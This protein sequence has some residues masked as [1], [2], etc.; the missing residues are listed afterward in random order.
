MFTLESPNRGDSN[1][2]TQYT[3]FFQYENKKTHPKLSQIY[4]YGIFFKGLKNE[5]ERSVVNEPSVFES[6]KFYC[7]FKR[8][9]KGMDIVD[10]R[11]TSFPRVRKAMLTEQHMLRL[12]NKLLLLLLQ[13][14]FTSTVNI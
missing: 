2:Y 10:N 7:N 11:I 6:L 1:E 14:C 8:I 4:S 5:F 9:Q 12:T 13:C 3:F